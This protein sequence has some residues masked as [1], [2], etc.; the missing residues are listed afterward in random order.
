M[1]VPKEVASWFQISKETVDTLRTE[2]AVAKAEKIA[3]EARL[4]ALQNSFDWLRVNWNQVQLE[5]KTMLSKLHGIQVPVPELAVRPQGDFSL[6]NLFADP[7][8]D[9][10]SKWDN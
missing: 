10:P 9:D 4:S 3:L 6:Q 5:N 7:R 2:L 8:E 1:W